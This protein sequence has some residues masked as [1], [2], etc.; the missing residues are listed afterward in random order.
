M[1]ILEVEKITKSYGKLKVLDNISFSVSE[2][3]YVALIGKNGAGKTTLLNLLLGLSN[4]DSGSIKFFGKQLDGNLTYILNNIGIVFQQHTLDFD[5]SVKKN[6]IFFADVH[7]M[8]KSVSLKRIKELLKRFELDKFENYKNTV[9]HTI[10][11][12]KFE[13]RNINRN[14]ILNSVTKFYDSNEIKIMMESKGIKDI[15]IKKFGLG[16]VSLLI[17]SKN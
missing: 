3:D 7:G 13:I 2:G 5:L 4:P 6:L 9:K 16:L 10:L 11:K 14:I 17:G 15:T 8:D 12:S 1:K